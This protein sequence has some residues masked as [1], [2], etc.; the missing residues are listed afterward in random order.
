[1]LKA[2]LKA[3]LYFA[4]VVAGWLAA[5]ALGIG[6]LDHA[7]AQAW[8]ARRGLLAP[9]VAAALYGVLAGLGSPGAPLTIAAGFT[10]GA[11]EG[12]IVS[13][14]GAN[15]GANLAFFLARAL[16]RDLVARLLG[17][18]LDRVESLAARGGLE[19]V[20]ALRLVPMIPFFAIN[21]ACGVIERLRWRDFAI[22]TAIGILPTTFAYAAAGDI[23]DPERR[24]FWLLLGAIQLLAAAPIAVGA[25]RRR[26]SAEGPRPGS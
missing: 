12:A 9:V 14:V 5:R 11:V 18:R 15:L 26:G 6:A 8:V 13:L 19:V 17:R 20:I 16:G 25:W 23:L 4:L 1:V 7:A 22:G 24:E 2:E 3:L 10:F 21:F